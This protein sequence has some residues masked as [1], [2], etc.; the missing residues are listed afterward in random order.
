MGATE[1]GGRAVQLI[2]VTAAA[3]SIAACTTVGPNYQRP[4]L[5]TPSQFRFADQTAQAESLADLPW[6]QV[7]DDPSLQTLVRE[8]VVNN[9]DVRVAAA[10]GQ[11][12]RER[13]R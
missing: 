13:G 5:P 12:L 10:R 4:P 11:E 1:M 7:F 8:A 6:W 9:L 3:A 2:L